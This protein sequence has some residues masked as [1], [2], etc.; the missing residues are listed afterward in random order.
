M[1]GS[2]WAG[3]AAGLWVVLAG[4]AGGNSKRSVCDGQPSNS[5]NNALVFLAQKED[6]F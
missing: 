5:T 1:R 3:A 6:F 4:A 2:W